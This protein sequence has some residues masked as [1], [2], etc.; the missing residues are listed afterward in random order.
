MS[1]ELPAP[2][3][4]VEIRFADDAP[5]QLD[6]WVVPGGVL[7]LVLVLVMGWRAATARPT[8]PQLPPGEIP[9]VLTEHPRLERPPEAPASLVDRL[10]QQ[11]TRTREAL[12]T[13]LDG[14]FGRDR[15]DEGMLE[16][17]EDVLLSADV[18]VATTER[19]VSGLRGRLRAGETDPATLR[20]GLKD[21]VRAVLSDVQRPFELPSAPPAVVLVVGVNGSGKTTTIG[22]L[23]ARFRRDGKKVL[24]AA[25]DTFRAA[26]ADQLAIWAERTGSDIVREQEGADP[27]S[28][29][30]K[31]LEAAKARGADVVV[32]D[33]A[34][35]LQTRKD[36]MEELTKIRRV[37][38][39]QVPDGPH[40]T[41]LVLD[42]T[43][44]QNAMS[45][46]MRFHEATP[47]T[48]VVVTKL[49]GTA[50]GGMVLAIAS[51]MK[52]P[53][54]FVGIGEKVDD[55]RPFEVDAFVD[56]LI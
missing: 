51:E 26:A 15:F 23:A 10:R 22:K 3:P 38:Q 49:D 1:P 42:G 53:V 33:T 25:G 8:P 7:G 46:A 55:L 45:Q 19:I 52:L 13:R 2:V 14:L 27:A 18:G 30:F 48:G 41:L 40:E 34:G 56:A 31:A 43:M 24:L 35:R 50:K 36:L 20:A 4:T 29:C 12:Q 32:V 39:K 47:L 54:K 28:V 11:L 37:V 16:E 6:D 5:Q 9:E 17:L 44:G 21:Q